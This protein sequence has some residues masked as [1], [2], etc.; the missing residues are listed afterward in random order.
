MTRSL[1]LVNGLTVSVGLLGF[2]HEQALILY[3]YL[4]R[5]DEGVEQSVLPVNSTTLGKR[6]G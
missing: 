2:C 5:E 6:L 4:P 1:V 3:V